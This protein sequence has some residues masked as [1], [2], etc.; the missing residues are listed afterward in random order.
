MGLCKGVDLASR[1]ASELRFGS[2]VRHPEGA[3]RAA[4]IEIENAAARRE[5]GLKK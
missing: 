4:S 1:E 3:H 5:A 2:V